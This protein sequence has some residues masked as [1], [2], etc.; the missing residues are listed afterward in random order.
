MKSLIG[1]VC[2]AVNGRRTIASIT[3]TS[4]TN[5]RDINNSHGEPWERSGIRKLCALNAKKPSK[6]HLLFCSKN[7]EQQKRP[8]SKFEE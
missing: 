3:R 1:D 6:T 5:V 7:Q 2:S 8:R 4:T